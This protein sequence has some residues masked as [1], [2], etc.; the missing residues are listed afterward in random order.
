M[1]KNYNEKPVVGIDLGTTNSSAA[2]YDPIAGKAENIRNEEGVSITPSAVSFESSR[3][4]IVGRE[5]K[6]CADIYPEY[7]IL[8]VKRMMGVTNVAKIIEGISYSPPQISAMILMKIMKILEMNTNIDSREVIITVPAYFNNAAR[9]ATIAAAEM[10]GLHVVTLLDEPVA[11]LYACEQLNDLA[12]KTVMVYD[13]GGGTT[14]IV[15]AKIDDDTINEIVI[16]GD[17]QLGGED[18]NAALVRYIKEMYLKGEE[19]DIEDEQRLLLDVE[20]VKETL[21]SKKAAYLTLNTAEGR[22]RI[23]VTREEFERCTKGL[24]ERVR[25]TMQDVTR[26]LF[27]KKAHIDKILLVGGATRMPQIRNLLEEM[28][29]FT[30]V[31]S[32]DVD[33]AVSKGAAIYGYLKKMEQNTYK[34]KKAFKPKELIRVSSRS[35]GIEALRGDAGEKVVCNLIFKGSDLPIKA[36]QT[37]HTGEEGQKQVCLKVYETTAA[38]KYLEPNADKILGVYELEIDEHIKRHSDI[39]VEL[40]LK[41]DGT[42]HLKAREPQT[43]AAIQGTMNSNALLD[44]K[45][46][47]RQ[48]EEIERLIL[49]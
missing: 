37:F 45:E 33:L 42:L 43:G 16:G 46:M 31:I 8:N 35:Y 44:D 40:K 11:A 1:D 14:D 30:D 41:E 10:A 4:Y 32:K 13:M 19:L 2:V 18:Y 27:D 15:I 26:E 24:Q 47:I 48:K 5:A 34:V 36:E 22:K 12:N 23:S 38:E 39:I 28:F 7:T 6:E 21:S 29:P 25:K 49:M 3:K 17:S 20:D 9:N